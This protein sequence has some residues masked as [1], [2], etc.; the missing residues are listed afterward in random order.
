M[1]APGRGNSRLVRLLLPSTLGWMLFAYAAVAVACFWTYSLLHLRSDRAQ[2]LDVERVRLRSVNAALAAGTLAMVDD[3]VGS[4]VDAANNIAENGRIYRAT[5]DAVAT[6]LARVLTGGPYV[7]SVFLAKVDFYARAG[8]SGR[9]EV[10]RTPPAWAAALP[11]SADVSTWVGNAINAPDRPGHTVVPIAR[12]AF[13]KNG[14][15]VL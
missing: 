13:L 6:A 9:R 14:E 4:A 11:Q 7:R 5:E 8:I 15:S 1:P 3:G 10:T 2:T 12:R